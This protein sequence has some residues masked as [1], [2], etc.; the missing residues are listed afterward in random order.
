M[1]SQE[2]IIYRLVKRNPI[3]HAYFL[4]LIFWAGLESEVLK[5]KTQPKS[6]PTGWNFWVSC[7]I[8]SVFLKFSGMNPPQ[9]LNPIQ[10]EAASRHYSRTGFLGVIMS[11]VSNQ[12]VTLCK[13]NLFARGGYDA[14]E[15]WGTTDSQTDRESLKHLHTA[16]S[17]CLALH[18]YYKVGGLNF[19]IKRGGDG[20]G[21]R[22]QFLLFCCFL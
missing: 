1:G 3:C 21:V 18:K 17:E 16:L 20:G 15:V 22:G 19:S 6:R 8:G 11:K 4:I 10:A 9:L 13:A 7:F 5:V 12:L 2:T 14:G